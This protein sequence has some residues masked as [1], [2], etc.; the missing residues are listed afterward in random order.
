MNNAGAIKISDA[1]T[2]ARG[3]CIGI[4]QNIGYSYKQHLKFRQY[5]YY[6][7]LI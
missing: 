3:R 7:Y 2:S 6:G 1:N 5:T 4:F